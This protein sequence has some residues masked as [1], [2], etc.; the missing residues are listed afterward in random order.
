ME[1]QREVTRE[2]NK[3][4]KLDEIKGEVPPNRV[5]YYTC[6]ECGHITKTIDRDNGVTPFMFE[7]EKEGCDEFGRSSFYRDIFPNQKPTIEWYRPT[8]KQT[9]KMRK[10]PEMLDHIL[11]G[12]LAHRKITNK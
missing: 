12:G 7:C 10:T 4:L 1:S 6:P 3:M 11:N 9:I 2:Y 5:N 8:L